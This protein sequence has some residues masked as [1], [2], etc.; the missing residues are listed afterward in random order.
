MLDDMGREIRKELGESLGSIA[1][2]SLPLPSITTS[3][4]EALKTY[5]EGVLLQMKGDPAGNDLIR[6]AVELDPE[7]AMAHAYL[8]SAAY[9]NGDGVA[10]EEHFRK[11]LSLLDRLTMRERLWIEALV[12]DWRGNKDSAVE[13]Y[14][15]YLAQYPDD[16]QGWFR[17]GYALMISERMEASIEAFERVLE[18]DPE[19]APTTVNIATC[20]NKLGRD[21]EAALKYQ[22]AFELDPRFKTHRF[23]NHEYGFLLVGMGDVG[24]AAEHFMM[25]MSLEDTQSKARGHRSLALLDMYL[26]RYGAAVDHLEEAVLINRTFGFQVSEL[27]DRIFL[28]TALQ[29]LG[30]EVE[31]A[32]QIAAARDLQHQVAMSPEWL[33]PIGKAYARMGNIAEASE[34]LTEMESRLTDP[35]LASAV[36][37]MRSRDQALYHVLQAEIELARGNHEYALELF[38][39]AD[40][41]AEGFSRESTA[42]CSLS[43]GDRANAIEKY[44][45]LRADRDLGEENQQAWIMSHYHLGQLY[46]QAGRSDEAIEAYEALLDVWKEADDNLVA[47]VDARKRLAGLKN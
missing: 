16:G 45:A 32:E 4:L 8:G 15:T 44:E 43:R 40:K 18:I 14:R 5:A 1:Q 3:S 11:A 38:S 13:K 28:I 30:R 33:Y 2:Q 20:L 26:G 29:A 42:Y 23:I 6:R 12:E 24:K 25:M 31:A 10:G 36:N 27:R 39:L 17:L 35:A 22:R 34:I 19:D 41:H 47:A 7:F 46:E 37:R 9:I 21:E